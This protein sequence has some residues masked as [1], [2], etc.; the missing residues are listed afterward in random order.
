M[1]P[2]ISPH[3]A[4]TWLDEH[5]DMLYRYALLQVRDPH[6]AEELVQETLL[7][8]LEGYA[9][10][11]GKSALRSWLI[12]ILKHKA[13]DH[14]RRSHREVAMTNDEHEVA[15]E[16]YDETEF[17]ESFTAEGHWRQPVSHWGEPQK[18]LEASQFWQLLEQCLQHLP[19]KLRQ[20]YLLREVEEESS[21]KICQEMAISATNL[22]TQLYRARMGLRRCFVNHWN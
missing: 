5:G 18:M 20:I 12:A 22:W 8:A 16:Q 13:M 3:F 9:R 14:F 21:E 10:Y 2:T 1:P 6:Q 11:D 7:A 19:T 4:A 15:P 17:D